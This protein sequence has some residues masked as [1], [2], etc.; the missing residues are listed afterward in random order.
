[1]HEL[2]ITETV[3]YFSLHLLPEKFL[4]LRNIQP[5]ITNAHRSS[6]KVPLFLSDLNE[7]WI[8]STDFR[9]I[10]KDQFSCKSIQREPIVP[11]GRTDW[12]TLPNFMYYWD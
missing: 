1:V 7:T 3:V 6:H 2:V 8:F 10:L 11:C 4:I 12:Q 5:D 9:K